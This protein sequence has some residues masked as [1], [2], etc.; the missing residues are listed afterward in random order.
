MWFLNYGPRPATQSRMEQYCDDDFFKV[1]INVMMGITATF[2]N[3][4]R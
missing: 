2:S 3:D 1:R 4:A